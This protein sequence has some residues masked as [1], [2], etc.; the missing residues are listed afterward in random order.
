MEEQTVSLAFEVC[1]RPTLWISSFLGS[2][3]SSKQRDKT[4]YEGLFLGG[5]QACSIPFQKCHELPLLGLFCEEDGNVLVPRYY[6]RQNTTVQYSNTN[7]SFS[8][9]RV[10]PVDAAISKTNAVINAS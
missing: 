10:I 7:T 6:I 2:S 9:N 3:W 5:V 1:Y 8:W 4:P